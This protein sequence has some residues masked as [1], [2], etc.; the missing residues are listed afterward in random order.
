MPNLPTDHLSYISREPLLTP[1]EEIELGRRIQQRNELIAQESDRS[2]TPRER[3]IC[4]R[5]EKARERMVTANLRLVAHVARRYQ[6]VPRSMSYADIIQEG[7][8]GLMNAADKFDPERGYKFSTYAYWWIRQGITRAISQQDRMIKLPINTADI[9]SK[10]RKHARAYFHSHGQYPTFDES[11]AYMDIPKEQ[12]ERLIKMSTA[13]TSLNFQSHETDHE[14]ID[15]VHDE[16]AETP[17]AAVDKV[18]SVRRVRKAVTALPEDE[19]RM[20]QNYYGLDGRPSVT[21][22]DIADHR[23]V[24][25]EAIRQRV[26]R[27]NNKLRYQLASRNL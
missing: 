24:S 19:R 22:G 13:V 14:I 7:A 15:L 3:R 26:L 1:T 4:R 5:G 12:L 20:I 27:I 2:L 23:S 9:I 25:R 17:L 21:L 10:M 6:T 16:T 18:E 8:I 11:A